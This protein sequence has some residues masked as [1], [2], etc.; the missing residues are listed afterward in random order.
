MAHT[1]M[2]GRL[3]N[4]CPAYA[5]P[6]VTPEQVTAA[7]AT[8][9]DPE[10][11]RPITELGMVESTSAIDAGRRGHRRVLLTV[12]GCPMRDKLTRDVTAAVA[13]VRRRHRRA[14]RPR[15]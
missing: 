2:V 4:S 5:E 10:I 14:G 11:R 1:I 3:G 7:L 12:A 13:A 9:D 6:S 8:V 15:A